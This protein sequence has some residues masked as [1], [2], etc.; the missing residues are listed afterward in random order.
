MVRCGDMIRAFDETAT[1][2]A[3]AV[4]TPVLPSPAPA[5]VTPVPPPSDPVLPPALSATPPVA[6]PALPDA[7]AGPVSPSRPNFYRD[8]EHRLHSSKVAF[9]DPLTGEVYSHVR[10][11]GG[12]DL[13][14]GHRDRGEA[15]AAVALLRECLSE[16]LRVPASLASRLRKYAKRAPQSA[17]TDR[18]PPLG[19]HMVVQSRND[20]FSTSATRN[21]GC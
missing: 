7:V 9:F 17:C 21:H 18:T 5:V 2:P 1:P 16:E 3:P 8:S 19:S 10:K 20:L 12:L 6:L 13:P 15:S 11:D 4:V 14:G